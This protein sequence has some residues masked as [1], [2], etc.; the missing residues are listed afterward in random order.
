MDAMPLS[1][2][3]E[4][5]AWAAQ[6][7]ECGQ[8]LR[9]CAPRLAQLPIGGSAVGTGVN[10]PA[11][12]AARV[13]QELGALTGVDF[14][15]ADSAF[16][17]MAGQDVA[18]ECS[19]HLRATA[20]VHTKIA[21]DLRWMSS[22]P[23][24][25]LAEIELEA[26]QPGSSI[27]P[28]KVNPV[29]PEAVLMAA[30]QVLGNDGSIALAAQ[31]GNFQLNVMLPLIADKLLDS[32]QLV[33]G[34]CGALERTIGGFSVNTRRLEET[35]AANPILVTALNRHIGYEQ[36]AHIAKRCFAERRPVLDVAAEETGLPREEL[37]GLLDPRRLAHPQDPAGG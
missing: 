8:R 9:E 33:A 24:A 7:A 1:M 16:A 19:S 14:S 30:A 2:G 31:S 28:G 29:L 4:L 20:V 25:G 12:F 32:L 3:Q 10:V 23:L 22:G 15:L 34:A 27:M 35:L 36:A 37:A 5:Q 11:G 21:N 18:L 17:R 13:A 26:L 6:L